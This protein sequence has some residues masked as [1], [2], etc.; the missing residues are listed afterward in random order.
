MP[1]IHIR[2]IPDDVLDALKRR[3]AMNSRSL[4]MEIKHHL[5]QL[6]RETLI[7]SLPPLQLEMSKLEGTDTNW[8]RDDIY[9]DSGR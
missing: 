3:A 5:T 4:Q 7:T 6:A 8:R 9:G 1:A 2:D